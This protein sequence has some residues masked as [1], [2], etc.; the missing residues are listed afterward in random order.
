M[1]FQRQQS[2]FKQQQLLL[3]CLHPGSCLLGARA[4]PT[5]S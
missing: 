2:I 1:N 3:L 5:L 4:V